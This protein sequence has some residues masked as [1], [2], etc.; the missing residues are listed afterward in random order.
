MRQARF[1]AARLNGGG[2][3]VMKRSRRSRTRRS[4]SMARLRSEYF[5]S[6][7]ETAVR[8]GVTFDRV[9]AHLWRARSLNRQFSLRMVAHLEDLVHAVACVDDVGLAWAELA[10][11]Y[12]RALIRRCRHGVAEI[13]A[14]IAVRRMLADLRRRNSSPQALR[15]PTLHGYAGMQ[16][17]RVWLGE[18]ALGAAAWTSV[19]GHAQEL[20][21][22]DRVT[23]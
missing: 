12:E 21:A 17:L 8:Y 9:V 3:A 22:G 7:A 16:P 18:R 20:V 15:F 14:T 5:A 23:G 1:G 6:A 10:D 4:R 2:A 13:D 19:T 11:R